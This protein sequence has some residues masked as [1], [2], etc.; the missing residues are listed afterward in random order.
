MSEVPAVR[1][2]SVF[3]EMMQSP[4][5]LR[6]SSVENEQRL[7]M[8]AV[9]RELPWSTLI[10]R[11][12]S[13]NDRFGENHYDGYYYQRDSFNDYAVDDGPEDFYDDEEPEE[14]N[15]SDYFNQFEGD[16]D[17]EEAYYSDVD[18]SQVRINGRPIYDEWGYGRVQQYARNDDN[19][20]FPSEDDREY[21][22]REDDEDEDY[23]Y[24]PDT[25]L[26]NYLAERE[27]YA[28]QMNNH[29][30]VHNVLIRLFNLSA[31]QQQTTVSLGTKAQEGEET[32]FICMENKPDSAFDCGNS[33]FCC[34]CAE[35]ILET[36]RKCPLC[37]MTVTSF[38]P[39]NPSV[40]ES[41]EEEEDDAWND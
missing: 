12:R 40:E 22:P 29:Q 7:L 4:L 15:D 37:R 35:K 19:E 8:R 31:Q 3:R 39:W 10:L 17:Y 16:E 36:T 14:Q 5:I 25:R 1:M 23:R 41:K 6:D 34:T 9:L 26:E 24:E 13:E 33:G 2:R 38:R 32:C 30:R 11:D 20:D 27:L 28:P 18:L 21:Y